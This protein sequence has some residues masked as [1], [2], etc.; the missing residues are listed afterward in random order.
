MTGC[1]YA[2]A[3]LLNGTTTIFCDSHEIANVCD[4]EGIEWMLN[5]CRQ[6]PLSIFLTVP[7]T[8][9][10]TNDKIET[11]GGNLTPSKIGKLFDKWPEAIALGEKM[12]FVSVCRGDKRSHQS[13]TNMNLHMPAEITDAFAS[14]WAAETD[15]LNVAAAATKRI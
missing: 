4:I 6:S 11:S 15:I 1:A 5:D 13:Y 12:D 3:A 8:I 10:A 2:E 7:S 14:E 9:P